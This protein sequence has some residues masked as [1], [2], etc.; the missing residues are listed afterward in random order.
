MN[1]GD[2]ACLIYDS[3][4]HQMAAVLPFVKTGLEKREACLYIANDRSTEEVKDSFRGYG[5]NVDAEIKRGALTFS[6]NNMIPGQSFDPNSMISVLDGL[7]TEAMGK[8]YSGFR[9]SGEMTWVLGEGCGCDRLIEYEALL[10]ERFPSTL[11]GICQ[12]NRRRFDPEII[13]DVLRTHPVIIVGD[14]VCRNL[15]CESH[16]LVAGQMP[17]DH[18]IGWMLDNITQFQAQE[19]SL[20]H[21]IRMRDQFIAIAGHEL[22][23]PL[24]SIKMQSDLRLMER[25]SGRKTTPESWNAF[26]DVNDRQLRHLIGI[27]EDMLDVTSITRGDLR[28]SRQPHVNL[29]DLVRLQVLRFQENHKAAPLTVM[30]PDQVIGSWD[31]VRMGQVITNLISNAVKFGE[32]KPVDIEVREKNDRAILT[33]QDQG[34]GIAR[35]DRRRIF[36]L[37]E[38]AVSHTNISGFGLGLYVADQIVKAHQGTIRVESELGKGSLFTVELPKVSCS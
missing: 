18:G 19:E 15:Y 2:H 13:R 1:G 11:T 26:L 21:M 16:K 14:K 7:M 34:L 20:R 8:G 36:G 32:G 3:H 27:V 4:E 37:Y 25:H 31:P 10:N 30:A 29:S 12:Y 6:Q 38:R 9:A 22:R 28:L 24:T 35:E 33:V 23:T 5:I 17:A